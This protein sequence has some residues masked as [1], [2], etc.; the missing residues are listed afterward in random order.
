MKFSS[1]FICGL[2]A[3]YHLAMLPSSAY[4]ANLHNPRHQLSRQTSYIIT[5]LLC[6]CIGGGGLIQPVHAANILGE[7]DIEEEEEVS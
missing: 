7:V 2:L 4:A 3:S 1:S 5:A 6:L